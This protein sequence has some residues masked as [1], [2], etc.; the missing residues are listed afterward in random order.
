[1]VKSF[2][3]IF[4]KLFYIFTICMIFTITPVFAQDFN[5]TNEITSP[6]GGSSTGGRYLGTE[7]YNTGGQHT[8]S[9]NTRYSGRLS[10][11][12][13]NLPSDGYDDADGFEKST[14]YTLTLNMATEDWRNKFGSVSVKCEGSSGQELSNGRVTYVSYKKIKF[15]F[16]TPSSSYCQFVYVDLKSSNVSSVAFTGDN[17]WNLKTIY[18]TNPNYSSGSSGGSGGSGGTSTPTPSNDYSSIINNQNKNTEDIINNQTNNTQDII[19]NAN[20]NANKIT[21]AVD[22]GLNN[23]YTNFIETSSYLFTSGSSYNGITITLNS[24]KSITFS[25]RGASDGFINIM[26]IDNGDY[27]F[28]DD[29]LNWTSNQCQPTG[30]CLNF[31][32]NNGTANFGYTLDNSIVWIYAYNGQDYNFTWYPM[33]TKSPTPS[34][35]IKPQEKKCT[36]KIDETT[37]SINGVNNSINNSNVDNDVGNS[38]FNDFSSSDFGLSQIVTIPLNTIQQ[39]TSTSCVSLNIPIPFTN[40]SVPLPC[41]TEVYEQRIPTIYNIWKIVSF[42]I[43]AYLIALDIF[44]IVKGFKDPNSDKVEVLEL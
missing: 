33:L 41:M 25:G 39:L 12:I 36:S 8:Y 23:C 13:F 35:Y 42:G 30:Y 5:V 10:R 38:F 4:K 43:I 22:N 15:S 14:N 28:N 1:M 40:S 2:Y 17:N 20:E 18:K 34:T 21:D 44:H 37:N 19:E 11:I 3:F 26:T 32:N 16:K 31:P 29:I 9:V 27:Y 6:Q 24:D 7:I